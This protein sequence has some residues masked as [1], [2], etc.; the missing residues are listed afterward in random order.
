M[1]IINPPQQN[2]AGDVISTDFYGLLRIST[3]N[4][5]VL[6]SGVVNFPFQSSELLHVRCQFLLRESVFPHPVTVGCCRHSNACLLDEQGVR[7]LGQYPL[8]H[9]GTIGQ[10]YRLPI[11]SIPQRLYDSQQQGF[12]W[13]A[14]VVSEP[15]LL[16]VILVMIMLML[17]LHML[18][19]RCHIHQF[20]VTPVL[21]CCTRSS[22]RLNRS[23]TPSSF[24]IFMIGFE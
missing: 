19:T 1:D 10:E 7:P 18:R 6:S 14:F 3:A 24:S 13:I 4:R 12:V 8:L 20:D 9:S 23:K 17:Y 21:L 22:R 15:F 5:Q 16:L 2:V 11:A